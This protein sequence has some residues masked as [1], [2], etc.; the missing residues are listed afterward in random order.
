MFRFAIF[1]EIN[2]L[3]FKCI[4]IFVVILLYIHLGSLWSTASTL[5]CEDAWIVEIDCLRTTTNQRSKGLPVYC[6]SLAPRM[7]ALCFMHCHS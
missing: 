5:P 7:G 3:Q 2:P 4:D 6:I 1:R